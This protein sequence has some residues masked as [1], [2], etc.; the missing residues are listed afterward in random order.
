MQ[1]KNRKLAALKCAG[2]VIFGVLFFQFFQL[3][4]WQFDRASA[5]SDILKQ[6]EV[7]K[8]AQSLE[9]ESFENLNN[10]PN[11]SAVRLTGEFD[12][13][14]QVLLEEQTVNTRRGVRVLSLFNSDQP[15]SS[16]RQ[17]SDK[18]GAL[19]LRGWAPYVK[20]GKVDANINNLPDTVVTHDF[21][22][23]KA[24][25][26]FTTDNSTSAVQNGLGKITD[27]TVLSVFGLDKVHLESYFKQ[28]IPMIILKPI[29]PQK[30]TFFDAWEPVKIGPF[31]HYGY[32]VQWL[33]LGLIA[34]TIS[35]FLSYNLFQTQRV[36]RASK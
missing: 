9:I 1:Q 26:S 7:A 23:I 11:F 27:D 24:A 19:V 18:N 35:A 36:M 29:K 4:L 3:A 32:A 17:S 12:L 31:R 21:F 34:A 33:V 20:A 10:L 13:D 6:F 5:K 22:I 25:D 14:Q 2:V 16:E 8:T 30:W 28:P 15:K